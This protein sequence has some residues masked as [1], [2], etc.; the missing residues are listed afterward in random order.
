MEDGAKHKGLV[1]AFLEY[2]QQEIKLMKKVKQLSKNMSK[3]N[4]FA[5]MMDEEEE[6]NILGGKA[7]KVILANGR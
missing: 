3:K 1:M 2:V 6:S 4:K 5:D 7:G